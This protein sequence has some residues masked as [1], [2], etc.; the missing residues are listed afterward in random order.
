MDMNIIVCENDT[1]KRSLEDYKK[2]CLEYFL[3]DDTFAIEIDTDRLSNSAAQLSYLAL[4]SLEEDGILTSTASKIGQTTFFL[5]KEIYNKTVPFSL[6][7]EALDNAANLYNVIMPSLIKDPTFFREIS[8]LDIDQ[9]ILEAL[10]SLLTLS[11]L[12][13]ETPTGFGNT[14]TST[15]YTLE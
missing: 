1:S 15:T 6:S 11:V 10:L 9:S 7:Y 4:K 8:P 5:K 14:S 12:P 2:T 3:K 13:Q